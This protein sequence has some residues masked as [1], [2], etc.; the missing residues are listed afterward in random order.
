MVR[1][2]RLGD[3]GKLPHPPPP[4]FK[5][6]LVS[7]HHLSISSSLLLQRLLSLPCCLRLLASPLPL[8]LAPT[9]SFLREHGGPEARPSLLP[10]CAIFMTFDAVS[11]AGMLPSSPPLFPPLSPLAVGPIVRPG[12]EEVHPLRPVPQAHLHRHHPFQAG[13]QRREVAVDLQLPPIPLERLVLCRRAVPGM[14]QS[15][16]RRH[17]G[18]APRVQVQLGDQPLPGAM[19]LPTNWPRL[20]F[21]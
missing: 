20:A 12:Q 1:E 5:A 10:T 7:A 15:L 16:P 13:H 2:A 8:L 17:H 11:A 9:P 3:P 4:P 21:V 14:P 19:P 6:S 18:L